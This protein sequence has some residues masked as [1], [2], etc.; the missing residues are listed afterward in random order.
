MKYYF[1]KDVRKYAWFS[2]DFEIEASSEEEAI[3]KAKEFKEGMTDLDDWE[4]NGNRGL[5]GLP[6]PVSEDDPATELLFYVDEEGGDSCSK[7]KSF[8]CANGSLDSFDEWEI[9]DIIVQAK[10]L[11]HIAESLKWI[12]I[13]DSIDDNQTYVVSFFNSKI[14]TICGVDHDK[15]RIHMLLDKLESGKLSR[16]WIQKFI[17][18]CQ[19]FLGNVEKT[20]ELVKQKGDLVV[21]ISDSFMGDGPSVIFEGPLARFFEGIYDLQLT[22]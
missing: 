6:E 13:K 15:T 9:D 3:E 20:D 11:E 17:S 7:V 21:L 19:D 5:H 2:Y 8:V 14:G 10:L 4:L 1:K 12:E 18:E 22:Q 16:K